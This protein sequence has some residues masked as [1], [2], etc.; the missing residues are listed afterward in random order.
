M[1][2]VLSIAVAS[3]LLSSC[4]KQKDVTITVENQ[5]DM[6]R[7]EMVEVV[8]HL[9]K[10]NLKISEG[11]SFVILD[12]QGQQ[13]PYQLVSYGEKEAQL[14][15]FPATLSAK[16]KLSF[17]VKAGNPETFA[18]QVQTTFMPQRKDDISWENDRAAFRMYGPALEVDPTEAMVS[19]GIDIWV[20]K[21]PNLVTQQ[22][23]KDDLA[24][25]KSYHEDHGEGLDF[26]SVGKT[27]G[28]GAAAPFANDSLYYISHNFQS[29]E[30]LDNGPLRTVF[31]LT[32]AP[33][34]AADSVLVNET[35][36]ISLDAGSNMNKIVE[37]YGDIKQDIQVA[38]G[39]PYYNNDTYVMNAPEGY[40][41]YAQPAHEQNGV[42]YLGLVSDVALVDTKVVK[43]QL[44]GVMNYKP[45][46]SAGKGLTYYSGGGWSQGGF[47]TVQ[48]WNQYVAD[49]AKLVRNPLVVAVQ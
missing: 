35:R 34:Y 41:A 7:T 36:T 5:A 9:I 22:W 26:Y 23:Y 1:K 47:P 27:L 33:Y 25:V 32:Y 28:A 49:F 42:I 45:S 48:D 6:N 15:I 40:I 31:R 44:L 10:D 43:N 30:I 46:Y 24:K 37:N 3:I 19:G 29:Y 14:L 11:Q 21:T 18:P 12:E 20:K 8:W 13:V 39:F 2:K 38:A 16:Q 4:M 17:T